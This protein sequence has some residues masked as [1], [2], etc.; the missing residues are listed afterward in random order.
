M[1]QEEIVASNIRAIIREKGFLQKFVANRAGYSKQAFN[2]MLTGRR[3]IR[4][5]DI[6]RIANALGC[7]ISELYESRSKRAG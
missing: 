6:P 2:N 4:A 3:V 7:S 5:D 1:K